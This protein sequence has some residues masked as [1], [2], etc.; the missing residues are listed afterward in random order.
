M[1]MKLRTI[2]ITL[3]ALASLVSCKSEFETLLAS[4]DVDAKYKAA[5]E[6]FN[7]KK[8]LKA[9]QLFESMAV[10][11]NGTERD[12]T[13]QYY[14][15]LSNYRY[16][17]YYTAESNFAKFI[18]NFPRSPF[19]PDARFLRLD[20]MYRATYRWELDQTPTKTCLAAIAEYIQEYPS[21]KGHMEAC[22]KMMDD[23]YDRLDRK[24]YEN[25]RLYYKME[26]YLAARVALRNVLKDNADNRYREDILYYTAMASYHYA[27]LSVPAKQQERYLTFADD[28][29]NFIG[30]YPESKYRRELDAMYRRSQRALGKYQGADEE[31]E[32]KAKDFEKERQALEK[33]NGK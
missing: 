12:D 18:T 20:C 16:K 30:E 28:Y 7:N 24:A 22:Q 27:R 9:A 33:A 4:N 1:K 25:A 15:G 26:D 29:L 6:L 23:L 31:L 10:L 2:A 5:M 13:V 21:D 3:A 8:Y 17:D 11:T 14:W 19:T 32:L